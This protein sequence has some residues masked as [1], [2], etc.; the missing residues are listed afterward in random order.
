M[1]FSMKENSFR[2]LQHE[3]YTSRDGTGQID[4][5][6]G[7][8]RI[9]LFNS[10][11]KIVTWP[12]CE[13]FQEDEYLMLSSQYEQSEKE[14][15]LNELRDTIETGI[16]AGKTIR[17]AFATLLNQ[18][19]KGQYYLWYCDPLK[20]MEDYFHLVQPRKLYYDICERYQS[21]AGHINQYTQKYT[22]YTFTL[23]ATRYSEDLDVERVIYYMDSIHQGA[24]PIIICIGTYW[25]ENFFQEFILDGNHKAI[26]YKLTGVMPRV[27]AIEKITG[28]AS[29]TTNQ[30]IHFKDLLSP[31]QLE[32]ITRYK[33]QN[34]E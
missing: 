14:A 19:S 16:P 18:L 13:R 2:V 23:I 29:D 4:I 3:D 24:R 30:A 22:A 9:L 25:R 11:L 34:K 10:R 28:F 8:E 7:W 27:L 15:I 12:V 21:K 20:P 17:E 33:Y 5:I 6:E 1:M 31:A 32:Y 26:A